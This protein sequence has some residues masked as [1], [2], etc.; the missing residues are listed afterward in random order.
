MSVEAEA[1]YKKARE[2]M[3][4]RQIV[5]RGVRDERVLDAMRSVPRHLFVPENSRHL[6]YHNGPLT[7]G[8]GQ[9]ISQPY[10]V[11][12]MTEALALEGHE[13]VLEIGTGSGYQA[14]ILSRL[15]SYVYTV[16]RIPALANR[17]RA[18]LRALGY[19]NIHI[20]ISDGT[21]G[22]PEYAPYQGIIVTAASPEIPE[23]LTDQLTEGGQLVAPV[24]G[25]WSQ[26]LVQVRKQGGRLQRQ[27]L[28]SVAFVPL[29][30][31]HGW[32]E[33]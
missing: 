21:L 25:S 1:S 3:V 22:W 13:R 26:S 6:A 24:G 18:L 27:E 14:A 15:V 8:Q 19:D 11:A 33:K 7:I 12:L 9:T 29:I 32:P 17:A 20:C 23:P 30:G 4:C 5:A 31:K 28:T 16:E 10:I 2:T